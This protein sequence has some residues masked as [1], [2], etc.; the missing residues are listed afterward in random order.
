MSDDRAA[1]SDIPKVLNDVK[2]GESYQRLN[3]FGKV[4][5]IFSLNVSGNRV[6]SC[7]VERQLSGPA[8]AASGADFIQS[9]HAVLE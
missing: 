8:A 1:T 7:F 3:F 2:R 6:R 5:W 4:N 9:F